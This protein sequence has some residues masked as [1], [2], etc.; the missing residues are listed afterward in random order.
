MAARSAAWLNWNPIQDS[1]DANLNLLT[2]S[3]SGKGTRE[4]LKAI[5]KTDTHSANG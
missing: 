2:A 4:S 1:F 5:L 3:D